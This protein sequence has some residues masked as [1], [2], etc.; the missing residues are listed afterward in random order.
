MQSKEPYLAMGTIYFASF[1]HNGF[2]RAKAN[3]YQFFK[4]AW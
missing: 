3:S 1:Y 4:A 2:Q